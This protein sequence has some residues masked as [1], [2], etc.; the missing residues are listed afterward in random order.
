MIGSTTP[1]GY[2]EAREA[3]YKRF[4]GPLDQPLQHSTNNKPFHIDIYQFAPFDDREHWTLI[5]GGMSDAR[6]PIPDDAP[7]HITGYSEIFM[8]G[9]EPQPWMFDVLKGL[10]E[11]PFVDDTYL[12]WFHTIPNGKPMTAKP[13]L[14]TSFLLLPPYFEEQAFGQSFLVGGNQVQPLMLIPI[15]EAE[16]QFAMENGVE[17]LEERFESGGFDPI[18][19]ESRASFV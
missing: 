10:A 15:T 16:R 9:R 18:I 6:M 13:S 5:T 1:E 2:L 8:Y 4:F 11:M 3:H 14:L 19:D 12:H 17:A 7:Q